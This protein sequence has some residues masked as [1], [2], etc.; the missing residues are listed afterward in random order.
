MHTGDQYLVQ[1]FTQMTCD[2]KQIDLAYLVWEAAICYWTFIMDLLYFDDQ[3]IYFMFKVF[4]PHSYY[5]QFIVS[6][7]AKIA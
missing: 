6:D 3:N 1:A 2:N 4:R 7:N 5:T